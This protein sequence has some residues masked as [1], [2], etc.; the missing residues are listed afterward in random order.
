MATDPR[1]RRRAAAAVATPGSSSGAAVVPDQRRRAT[2]TAA[3]NSYN[4]PPGRPLKLMVA[5][6]HHVL[7]AKADGKESRWET[8][9]AAEKPSE[10][11]FTFE[12]AAPAAPAP[13]AATTAP[14]APAATFSAKTEAEAPSSSG[15]RTAGFVRGRVGGG[16]PVGGATPRLLPHNQLHP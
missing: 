14:T 12:S 9:L 10:H 2:G 5:A 15:M 6:G 3:L 4:A 8:D 1:Q 11:T 16:L 13:L 7:T